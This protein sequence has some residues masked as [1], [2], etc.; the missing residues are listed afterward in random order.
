M[1]GI[2]EECIYCKASIDKFG[3][4]IFYCELLNEKWK[5]EEGERNCKQ[6]VSRHRI[7]F[8]KEKRGGKG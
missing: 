7:R 2:C 5:E 6:F 8:D 4:V 1:K 3:D